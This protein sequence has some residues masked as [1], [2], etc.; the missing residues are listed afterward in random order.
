MQVFAHVGNAN[1]EDSRE[2]CHAVGAFPK[3]DRN[4]NTTFVA[5]GTKDF[6][7]FSKRFIGMHVTGIIDETPS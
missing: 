6:C 5:E 1:T 4:R 7:Y 2:F 3:K